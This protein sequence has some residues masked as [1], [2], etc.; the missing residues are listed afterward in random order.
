MPRQ[1]KLFL[2][3]IS[4][5]L[6][7][8]LI[9]S[10][11]VWWLLAGSQA[12]LNGTIANLSITDSTFVNRD[13]QGLVSIDGKNRNDISFALGF[14]HAQERLFQMDLLRRNSAGE[15]SELF[16]ER[17]ANFDKKIRI[18]QFRKRAKVAFSAL[19]PEEKGLLTHYAS[20]VNAGMN[21]MRS[22]P[23]EY[24]LLQAK[25][26]LWAAED[27]FLV[28]FSMYMDLLMTCSRKRLTNR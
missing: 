21:Q 25:P 3:I 12:K 18:H 22:K 24:H 23:F 20:G 6:I 13:H 16:G 28:V 15:L 8:S 14:I 17:A 2:K 26:Q 11:A 7:L 1:L 9:A 4:V 19:A 27:S 10:V 5:L